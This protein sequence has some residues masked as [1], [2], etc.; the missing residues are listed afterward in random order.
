MLEELKKILEEKEAAREE[1]IK[2]SRDMRLNSSKAIAYIHAGNFE[3]AEKH[4]KKAEEVFERIKKFKEKFWDIYYLSFD[5]MQEFVEAI[6]FKNVVENLSLEVELPEGLEP[7][8][9][10]GGFADSIGEMRRY[11]LT[12]LVKNNVEVAKK[13]LELME[14]LYFKLV[15]FTFH[16]KITGN[17]RPKLDVARNS[18][19][20][21]KSDLLSAIVAKKSDELLKKIS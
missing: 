13:V 1:L 12:L 4:L 21:T 8:P 11:A 16:D 17:L 10:L 2:L 9:I 19:E 6:V 5:A 7:A 20:R 14:E 15:E 3:K 18:I